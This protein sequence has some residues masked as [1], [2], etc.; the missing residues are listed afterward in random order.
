MV[1]MIFEEQVVNAAIWAHR[2]EIKLRQRVQPSLVELFEA[3]ATRR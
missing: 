2:V 3:D 1:Q